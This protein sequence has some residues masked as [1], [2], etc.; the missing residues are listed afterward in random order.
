MSRDDWET[1]ETL[2]TPHIEI[3][4]GIEPSPNDGASVNVNT[5]KK[6][7]GKLILARNEPGPRTLKGPLYSVYGVIGRPVR[8]PGGN[9]YI[10]LNEPPV[11]R[12]LMGYLEEEILEKELPNTYDALND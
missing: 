12:T 11:S 2:F 3:G 4:K 10:N 9:S 7:L 5:F 8:I 1:G 6:C